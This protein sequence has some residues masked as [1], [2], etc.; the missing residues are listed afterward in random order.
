VGVTALL[1]MAA[2]M[3]LG[4][5]WQA[6]LATGLILSLSSTAI[7]LQSLSERG[8]MKSEPGQNS[9][10]VLLFQYLA[11]IPMLAVM[12]LLATGKAVESAAAAQAHAAS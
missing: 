5:A 2:G 7:V 12:P 6:A 1:F 4:L 10:A 11:V 9:F 3:L 8:L